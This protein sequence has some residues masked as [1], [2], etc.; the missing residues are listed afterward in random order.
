MNDIASQDD[1]EFFQNVVRCLT[2][3]LDLS[4]SMVEVFNYLK[5]HYPINAIS[6]HQYS[7][8]LKA[9]KLLFL[10]TRSNFQYVET[11]LPLSESDIEY[12]D[13]HESRENSVDVSSESGTDIANRHRKAISHLLPYRPSNYLV[14][15]MKS[16]KEVVGHLC[17][18]GS[19]QVVYN[20]V[21]I[22]RMHYLINPFTL[23]MS[24]ML[25][26]KRTMEFQQ[27]LFDEKNSLERTLHQLQGS[28][29]I[30]IRGGMRKTMEVVRQLQGKETPALILGET[31]T[32]KELIA[33]EIQ[34]ISP[35]KDKPFIKVNC[36][37]IPDNLIDSELFGY[38]K[39][40]FTG[41]VQSHSGRF[42]QADGGTLFL[43]EIGEL[44]LQ[45]QVR[46]LRVLQNGV[47]ERIGGKQSKSINVRVIAATNRDLGQMIKK[48]TFREDLYYRLYV[49]PIYLP[50]LRDRVQDI[51]FFL[52]HFVNQSCARLNIKEPP[53]FHSDLIDH[54]KEY[55]W[56]GNVRE[57]ENLV[58]RAVILSSDGLLHIED[59]IPTSHA[60]NENSN[61]E[62]P[63]A[64]EELIDERIKRILTG[65]EQYAFRELSKD[66]G[67]SIETPNPL[68][69]LDETIQ[70]AIEAALMQCRGK[71]S[72]SNG[73]ARLLGLNP[74]TLRNKMRK[75]GIYPIKRVP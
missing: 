72:G 42:E 11:I 67:E 6:L 50:P 36:G 29:I 34:R 59:L 65:N 17:L 33:D 68:K 58:E 45:A 41:A 26:F 21:Q 5:D 51:P 28:P 43:D 71:V 75:S 61:M 15:I 55:T 69:P 10:V 66:I 54:L 12:L 73:A 22:K 49:F 2:G 62:S 8:Q 39:G 35:R 53:V 57:L 20:E 32:G 23:A 14:A 16:G 19:G 24:N 52:R 60:A 70:E 9:L 46:F 13:E 40:A 74:S 47:I 37:A 44:P 7:K 48:G 18:I 1:F 25:Q 27:R 31:G 64:L 63:Q 38:E 3:S 56:P 4:K 30:G